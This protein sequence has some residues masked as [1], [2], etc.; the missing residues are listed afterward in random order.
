MPGR[1]KRFGDP[2]G[3]KPGRPRGAKNRDSIEYVK[4]LRAEIERRNKGS[5]HGWLAELT[6]DQILTLLRNRVP[7]ETRE[8]LDVGESLEDLLLRN[9]DKGADGRRGKAGK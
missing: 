1:G 3:P 4:E 6:N 7:R 8:Q 2:G 5:K 9:W